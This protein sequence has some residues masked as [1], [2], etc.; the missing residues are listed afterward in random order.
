MTTGTIALL[1]WFRQSTSKGPSATNIITSGTSTTRG[2]NAPPRKY[3]I[4]M[5][6]TCFKCKQEGHYARDCPRNT[7][8]KPIETKMEKMQAPH[9]S[10]TSTER[11][12]IKKHI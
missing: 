2:R 9:K 4:H 5:R 10:M 1:A 11:A 6:R 7:T 3:V 8:Q 12:E